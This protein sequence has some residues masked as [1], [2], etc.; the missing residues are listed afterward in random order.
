MCPPLRSCLFLV[1]HYPSAC[2]Y[3]QYMAEHIL[4]VEQCKFFPPFHPCPTLPLSILLKQNSD[5]VSCPAAASFWHHSHLILPCL[6]LDVWGSSSQ[7][8]S[9]VLWKRR[10][11]LLLT[12]VSC[13]WVCACVAAFNKRSFEVLQRAQWYAYLLIKRMFSTNMRIY[14]NIKISKFC[15]PEQWFLRESWWWPK[16]T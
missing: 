4:H 2:I 15:G 11:K 3:H 13:G 9:R 8:T 1:F 12:R 14:W 7:G 16:C 5:P 10:L 6:E